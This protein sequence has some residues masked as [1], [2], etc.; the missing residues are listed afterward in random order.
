MGERVLAGGWD[1]D[2]READGI[3]YRSPGPNSATVIA[4]LRHLERV[5]FDAAPRVAGTGFGSDGR[6]TLVYIEGETDHVRVWD[7]DALVRIGRLLRELHEATATFDAPVDAHW[8][9]WFA[10]DLPG[11]RPVL[12]H[13]D[14]GPWNIVA[15]DEQPVAFIDWDDAGPVDALWELAQVAWLNVQLH[16]D[17]VAERNRLPALV[18]RAQQLRLL[19]DAYGLERGAREGFVDRMIE[20]AVHS[21]RDEAIICGVTPDTT[22]GVDE[23][24]F[25]VTWAITWRVRAASWLMTHRGTLQR[26]L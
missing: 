15:R 1:R 8:R 5:G 10:R 23:T 21:A 24:G 25:P 16:D 13:G 12:G 20:F 18:T 11:D 14:L 22:A 7:D 6:E 19:V 9:P 3:V 4:L 17:D 2:V 26:A